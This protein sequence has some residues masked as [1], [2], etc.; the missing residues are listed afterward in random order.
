MALGPW[1][2]DAV[3][4]GETLRQGSGEPP[5]TVVSFDSTRHE[6]AIEPPRSLAVADGDRF[7]L[8]IV[9]GEGVTRRSLK[10]TMRRVFPEGTRRVIVVRQGEPPL[11]PGRYE[12][13]IRVSGADGTSSELSSHAFEIR[14]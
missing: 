10:T 3:S 8:E 7:E 9:D 6:I 14:P 1:R 2:S 5:L 12:L 11:P 13:R 4:L